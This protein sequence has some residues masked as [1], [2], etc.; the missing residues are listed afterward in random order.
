MNS[1][2]EIC[3]KFRSAIDRIP[4]G[5]LSISFKDFPCGSCGDTCQVLGSLL[6]DRD[7]GV[8]DYVCGMRNER[9]HAWLEKD[10]L[11]EL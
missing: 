10:I 7:F 9:S 1:L 8:F 3:L 6:Q 4:K 2:Y 5:N 11:S